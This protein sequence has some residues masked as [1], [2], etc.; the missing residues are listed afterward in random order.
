LIV[1]AALKHFLSAGA[2]IDELQNK[3]SAGAGVDSYNLLAAF[4]AR[5]P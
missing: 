1:A 4:E 3:K 2:E 5:Y